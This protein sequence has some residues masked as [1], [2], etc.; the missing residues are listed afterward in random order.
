MLFCDPQIEGI[1][2]SAISIEFPQSRNSFYLQQYKAQCF[3]LG[4]N[5]NSSTCKKVRL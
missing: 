2:K 5:P 4:F 3:Q 1:P